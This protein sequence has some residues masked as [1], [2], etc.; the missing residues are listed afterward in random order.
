[1]EKLI[2][3]DGHSI[4]NR[5]FY[6]LPL[7]TNKDGQYTNAI[8][9]FLNIL[10]KLIE[11][12]CPTYIGVSFDLPK[13]TFRHLKYSDY[14][15]NRKKMPDE[16]RTQIPLI[17]EILKSMNVI[18]YEKEGYEADDV[19]ATVAKEAEAI[20]INPIIV[21]GDRDLL[22]IATENIKIKIPKTKAGKTE[23]EDYFEKDVVEKYSVTPKEFI[24]VKALMGDTSDNVPGVPSIGEKTAIKIINKYKTV[25]NAI[26]NALDIK[27]KR[28]GENILEYKQQALLSKYLVTID[29]NVPISFLNKKTEDIF[30][31][32]F[33][34][35]CQKYELKTILSKFKKTFKEDD[36]TSFN[37]IENIDKAKEYFNTLKKDE[38]IAYKMIYDDGIFVGIGFTTKNDTGTFIKIGEDVKEDDILNIYK[39]FFEQDYK[40]IT[41][42]AKADIIFLNK[43]NINIY[44][45]FFEQDYKKITIDAKEDILFLKKKNIEL[46]N[47]IFDVMIGAYVLNPTKN[48]YEYNHIAEEF[49]DINYPDKEELLGTKKSKKFIYDIEK[50]DWFNYC[51]RQSYVAY[52]SKVIIDKNIEKN[53]QKELFYNI[54]M[55]LIDVLANMQMYG[56][57]ICK[58][59]LIK[60]QKELDKEIEQL[61]KE[62]HWIAGEEF[63]IN[64]SK[65][66]GEILF[67]KLSLKGGKKTARGWST[68]ADVLE[69]LQDKHEI[70]PKILAYRTY[71]KLKS[72]YADGLLNVLDE[73]TSRIYSNFNQTVTAT[74]RIS[75][76]EPNLQN[77][78]IKIELGH[79]VRKVFIP[80][81]GYV[82]VDADYS[83]IEL[84]VLAHLSQDENLI[85]AFNDGDDIHKITASKVFKKP[86]EDITSFERSAAKAIN[87]G[88]IYGKQAFSLAQDLGITKAKAEEYI[89]DYF[90]KYPSIKIFL[91]RIIKDTKETGYTKTLFDRIRYVPEINSTNFIQR[92]AGERIAMNTPIQGT[93][94]DIIKIAMVKVYNRIKREGLKS[95][96]ILQVHD[97]LLIETYK[98]EKDKIKSILK[99]EMEDAVKFSVK[100]LIDINEG[101]N[102][103]DTK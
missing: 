30:N 21:S 50:K 52:K 55:P 86:I 9:G 12:E 8:Y 48:K 37:L 1:M 27:P 81:E 4:M 49:L 6:A 36:R 41:I 89:N 57:K 47:V 77:I 7:L 62:I 26:E 23:I 67:D 63:N 98:E 94:A 11:E 73:K 90:D 2:L 10:F 71:A 61:T 25:E 38:E 84:R 17:K 54:E 74:G 93:A 96:L 43:H 66:L 78:P 13:P 45:V 88:L 82:F 24:E 15:G 101:E 42:D 100:L 53:N 91:D 14:K 20:G 102:W 103:Y 40:K 56:I 59:D 64:S 44:K 39:V 75:S 76:T 69:K 35:Q 97:E 95:R 80:E 18:I 72:T 79:K 70:I 32:E 22:Q 28:A 34:K 92:G 60:Y 5:A 19:L 31:D 68:A 33:F 65:Q 3:I 83:Q 58:E 29:T 46:N 85:N 51:A 99:D 16:L 87:F